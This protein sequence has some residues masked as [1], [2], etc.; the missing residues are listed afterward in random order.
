MNRRICQIELSNLALWNC[1][2]LN[3]SNPKEEAKNLSFTKLNLLSHLSNQD[4]TWADVEEKIRQM[5]ICKCD[6]DDFNLTNCN[7]NTSFIQHIEEERDIEITCFEDFHELLGINPSFSSYPT[8]EYASVIISNQPIFVRIWTLLK[9][10]VT[11]KR[12]RHKE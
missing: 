10:I 2:Y 6:T 9:N 11:F 3:M 7:S 4:E 1:K 8:L 5:L 12:C